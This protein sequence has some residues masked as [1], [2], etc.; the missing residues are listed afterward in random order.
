MMNLTPRLTLGDL[1]LT[2]YPFA[3]EF[4]ADFGVSQN[5]VQVIESGL[6]DGEIQRVTGNANRTFELALLVEGSDLLG[7][8][9]AE[10]LLAAECNKDLNEFRIDPGDG[11][12]PVTVFST[13]RAQWG[14]QRD[15]DMEQHGYRRYSLTIS[16]LPFGFSE[17]EVVD[18]AVEAAP[19]VPSTVTMASGSS[20]TGWTSPA[21]AV[22][23]DG[24]RLLVPSGAPA[25][26]AD[27]DGMT[28]YTY[29]NEATF[30]FTATDFSGT[31]Y[32]SATLAPRDA[33]QFSSSRIFFAEVDGIELSLV[34]QVSAGADGYVFTWACR[35]ASATTLKIRAGYQTATTTG[36]F[37]FKVRDVKRSNVGPAG[38]ATGRSALR[39]LDVTG[40]ART[41]GSIVIEH[42]TQGL[43]DVLLYTSDELAKGYD[44]DV[45]GYLTIAGSTVTADATTVRGSYITG[46]KI[47]DVDATTL[48]E[49]PH[50][51]MFR[52]SGIAAADVVVTVR[53]M[54][55]GITFDTVTLPAVAVPLGTDMNVYSAG[56]VTLP[57]TKFPT[58]SLA[59]VQI[60]VA[61]NVRLD[62]LWSC[63]LGEGSDLTHV[64][65]GAGTPVR[66]AVHN[67][68]FLDAPT[69]ANGGAP[70]LYVG[71]EADRSDA[72]HPGY[73]AV[74]AWGRHPMVPPT[75][76][77]KVATTGAAYASVTR[78]ER[79]AWHTHAAS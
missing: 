18:V 14:F 45:T 68:L 64:R 78:R 47:F 67:R 55:D 63:Y 56:V 3:V 46:A 71:T 29:A 72:F 1:D 7:L 30:T 53:S 32:L 74:Q 58:Q 73:P 13:F 10:E 36:T 33:A 20:A 65:A 49:G 40:S 28:Y 21:G 4:G 52:A 42:P 17:D 76:L 39:T 43:G 24:T 26:S 22:T 61:G 11:Y 79:P 19:A 15:D 25:S 2:D 77:L 27:Y 75:M 12:A 62:F 60:E 6:D 35:D 34:S 41:A 66:G 51:L 23:S 57:L 48:P 8:A 59:T 38:S 37:G 5:I 31:H 54:I 50:V 9:M 69:V 16:A 44:P 70:A